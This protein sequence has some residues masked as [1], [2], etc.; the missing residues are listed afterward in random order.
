MITH[1]LYWYKLPNHTCPIT[2]G[3][4]GITNDIKRRKLQHKYQSNPKNL[5]YIDTH[6]Y[7]AV[8]AYGGL[9]ALVFEILHEG[10]FEEICKLENNYRP[11]L[12]IGWNVAVGG[13]MPGAVSI[14]KGVTDRWN[15]EQKANIS[16][17]HKGKKLSEDHIQTL[18]GKNRASTSLGTEITLYHK[19][20]PKKT[21]TYHSLSEASRQ[22]EIPLSR[23]K[24]KHLRKYSSYGDDGWAILFD[25][26]F[27]RS[28]TPTAKELRSAAISKALKEKHASTK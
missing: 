2:Q 4:I 19:D 24:S 16:K 15:E 18:K 28:S 23:L 1:Y 3:Y 11:Q 13:E 17:H 27:D 5:S 26:K 10:T 25:K 7:R 22:L 8:N 20:D 14:F 6:F 21:Y 9:D 12:N